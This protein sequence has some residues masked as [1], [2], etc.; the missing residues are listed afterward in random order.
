MARHTDVNINN[1][2]GCGYFANHDVCE[3]GAII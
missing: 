1:R 2:S 3:S